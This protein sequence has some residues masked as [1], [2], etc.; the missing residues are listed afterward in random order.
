MGD[1]K[2][3]D[4]TTD[5]LALLGAPATDDTM[6][7]RVPPGTQIA[8]EALS[9]TAVGAVSAGAPTALSAA[10]LGQRAADATLTASSPT[11]LPPQG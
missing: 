11:Q 1:S 9:V 3:R 7:L 8:V 2:P 4:L 6:P 5:E 10:D